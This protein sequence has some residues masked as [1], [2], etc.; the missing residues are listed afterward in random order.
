M[1]R[2]GKLYGDE[3]EALTT[4]LP[5]TDPHWSFVYYKPELA[6]CCLYFLEAGVPVWDADRIN[7]VF[8][9]ACAK[10]LFDVSS[11]N[12]HCIVKDWQD[13][14][15]EIQSCRILAESIVGKIMPP[16]LTKLVGGFVHL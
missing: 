4:L 7:R 3:L 12:L 8:D 11:T 15:F 10:Y 1:A 16:E 2:G 6:L 13:G 5:R 14:K 9:K